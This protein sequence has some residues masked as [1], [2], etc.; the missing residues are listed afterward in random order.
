[1]N[2]R[3]KIFC[4]FPCDLLEL[5]VRR[6]NQKKFSKS[7]NYEFCFPERLY[8]LADGSLFFTDMKFEKGDKILLKNLKLENIFIKNVKYKRNSTD[9]KNDFFIHHFNGQEKFYT[10]NLYGNIVYYIV[11][12]K[13]LWKKEVEK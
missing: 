8:I 3:I 6:F 12:Y 9:F 2:K 7:I 13:K 11:G 1:M 5:S 4:K 10:C